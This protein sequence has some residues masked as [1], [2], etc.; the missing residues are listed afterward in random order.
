[1]FFFFKVNCSNQPSLKNIIR[2]LFSGYDSRTVWF[3]LPSQIL[4]VAASVIYNN[5]IA[6]VLRRFC[7]GDRF[8]LCENKIL[9]EYDYEERLVFA[10]MA[11][12]NSSSLAHIRRQVSRLQVG[13]STGQPYILAHRYANTHTH[14]HTAVSIVLFTPRKKYIPIKYYHRNFSTYKIFQI[15]Q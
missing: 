3:F 4:Y 12:Y 8:Y 1:M 10:N 2:F 5:T 14:T 15:L 13:H 7:V 6:L 9:C 11:T